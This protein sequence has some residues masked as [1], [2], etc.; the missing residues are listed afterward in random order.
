MCM[1]ARELHTGQALRLWRDEL[2]ALD[3]APFDVGPTAVMVAYA[4]QAE[5][6]CFLALG[7]P[8]PVNVL[9]LFAEHRTETN[10]QYLLAGNGLLGALAHRGLAH[11]DAGEKERMRQLV[12]NQDAWTDE[13][14]REILEY[15]ASDVAG[16]IALLPVMAND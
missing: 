13:E 7:W 3:R 6:G 5:L 12:M 14:R 16:L 2:I 15:C 9:D 4:A 11:I 10:G 1:A 8:L